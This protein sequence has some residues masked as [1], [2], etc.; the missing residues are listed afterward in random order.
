MAS[1]LP[2]ARL[3]RICASVVSFLGGFALMVLEVV[4]ARYLAR[5]FGS[6]FY[7]WISQISTILVAL[8]VGYAIGGALVDRTG[9]IS[10]LAWLLAPA[11]IFTIAI[12]SFSD[13]VMDWIVLR[14]PGD[15]EIP[16]FWQ[17]LDPAMGSMLFFLLPCTILGML[18]PCMVKLSADRLSLVGGASGLVSAAGTAGSVAG[19]LV[20]GYI[21]MDFLPLDGIVQGTGVGLVFLGA[22]CLFLD[23]LLRKP[24]PVTE[25]RT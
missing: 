8:G 13:R 17:R 20:S 14:H 2:A 5:G 25:V 15:R 7:V 21:L 18:S 6:S 4:G 19:V 3:R 10:F 23:G 16:P 12:P 11:G 24:E 9:S 1:S 22:A